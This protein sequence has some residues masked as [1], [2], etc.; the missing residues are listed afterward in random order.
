MKKWFL[1]GLTGESAHGDELPLLPAPEHGPEAIVAAQLAA[2][3]SE[4]ARGVFAFAS[5]K[6]KSTFRCSVERFSEMLGTDQY[7]PLLGHSSAQILQ[8]T[9]MTSDRNF[10]VVGVVTSSTSASSSSHF[11]Q[12]S[13]AS[14]SSGGAPQRFL[15]GW[16]LSLQ[17]QDETHI[18]GDGASSSSSS[19]VA[20]EKV[21]VT[22]GV[23]PL[24]YGAGFFAM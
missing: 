17:E 12:G 4:D 24:G 20:T 6:N 5:R 10:A 9:Q 2:L 3:K 21:W 19:N 14:S 13:G 18:D 8:S 7:S 1:K 16:S 15:F 11:S 22:E 23:Y